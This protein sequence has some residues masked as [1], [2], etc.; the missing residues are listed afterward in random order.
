MSD[1]RQIV[2]AYRQARHESFALATLVRATGSSY[3]RPGAR[4][5]VTSSGATAGSLSAGCLEEEV[6]ATALEV[7]VT[8]APRLMSFD[9]RR[10]FGC[11]GSIDI[12]VE[13]LAGEHLEEIARAVEERRPFSITTQFPAG[14]FVQT[15]E[16][17]IR[18]VVVGTGPDAIAL[19]GQAELLG[20]DAVLIESIAACPGEIDAW[21]AAVIATHNYGRDCA[22]LRHLLPL[23]LRYL[24]LIG[25]RRRRDELLSDV[26]D[27]GAEINSH[28]FAPAGL[29]LGAETPAEIALCVAAEIQKLFAQGTGASLCDSKRPIHY[30]NSRDCSGRGRIE[31]ARPAETTC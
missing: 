6:A 5:L 1:I 11:N 18:V 26:L 28:L 29:D 2:A 12:F 30:A 22:A 19:Q 3:R 31:P 15:I 27:S 16:P 8:D 13:P 21:T 17:A 9:T 20:W 4:M 14:E 10:R 23:G 24:A 7:I 25:P